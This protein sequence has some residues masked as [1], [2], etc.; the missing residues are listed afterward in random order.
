MKND[1]QETNRFTTAP[2][3][4]ISVIDGEAAL[5]NVRTG[6]YFGLNEVGTFI[7]EGYAEGKSYEEVV[8]AICREF[9]V[10]PQVAVADAKVFTRKI[11]DLGLLQVK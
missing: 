7:W 11:L 6:A 5:L 8:Q 1:F 2:D 4:N 9:S 10:D 3:V